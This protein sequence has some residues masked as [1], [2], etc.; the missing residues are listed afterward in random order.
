LILVPEVPIEDVENYTKRVQDQF[1]S[2]LLAAQWG[3][4]QRQG[5]SARQ[6]A[7]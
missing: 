3:A 4:L 5:G 2:R 7:D 1:L 6:R